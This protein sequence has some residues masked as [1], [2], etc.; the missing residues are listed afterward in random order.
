MN[1]I[2]SY[3]NGNYNV[4]IF[5]DGT[6][7][8]ENKL[9]FFKPEFPESFDL[10]ITN[11]CDRGCLYCHENSIVNG[12]HG[13]ILNLPFIDSMHPYTEIAIGG[14]NPLEHPDLYKFLELCKEKQFIPSMTVNQVHFMKYK[15][16]LKALCD[17]KLIYGLGIS[18]TNVHE[19][20][21]IKSVKEFPNAVIHVING[22]VSIDELEHLSKNN[23]KILILGY[24]MFRRGESYYK[25]FNTDT[26][27]NDINKKKVELYVKLPEIIHEGWFR[28]VSFDNLAIKQLNPQR[29]MSK[30]AW[31][32]MY[33]GDDG[34]DGEMTSASMYVD[35]VK[36]EFARNSCSTNRYPI[37]DKI[38]DM[39]SF[40]KTK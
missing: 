11:K 21:F 25:H 6:K 26:I 14:G 35:M 2:G 29:I 27:D 15:E 5:E 17:E 13:D 22:I 33:M 12:K 7:V 30:E 20:D 36:R 16:Y 9:D 37:T 38:E 24:K 10:K 40:L 39:F 32:E 8:R 34:I 19:R 4:H 1:L 18:L 28:V 23:L 31:D 3:K